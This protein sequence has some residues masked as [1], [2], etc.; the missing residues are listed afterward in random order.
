MDSIFIL[1]ILF[2]GAGGC[3][4]LQVLHAAAAEEE[5]ELQH[6]VGHIRERP[7]Q[8][9]SRLHRSGRPGLPERIDRDLREE[10]FPQRAGAWAT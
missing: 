4:L 5:P 7:G 1:Y 8:E 9:V 6:Q 10:H 2:I 3:R